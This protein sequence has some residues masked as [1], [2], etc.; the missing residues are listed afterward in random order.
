MELEKG[1]QR[2]VVDIAEWEPSSDDFSQAMAF[3]PHHEY[4]SIT[5]FV[6]LEDRK[7]A[8]VSR[9]LQYALVHQVLGITFD[10]IVIRRTPEGK[11]FLVGENVKL[12]F[13]NFNFNA[14]HHGDYV[15]IAS[16]PICLVG[17][18]IVSHSIPVN[19]TADKFIQSFSSYF[20]SLEWYCI[21]NAGSSD[22]MLKT[23]YRYWSLKESF[24][25]AM[26]SGVGYKLDEVE[27][28][29]KSWDDI[30]VKVAG[31]KLKDWKFWLLELGQNHSVSIARGHP[32]TAITSYKRTLKQTEFDDKEYDLG[33]H[34]PNASFTFLTV[35]DLI[36]LCS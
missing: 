35:K 22:E 33:L 5:R 24:V 20:S 1:V 26:G 7:R 8:L 11:P 23:F 34:L 25:K 16:E 10:D 28:H 30:F 6:K 29:H 32:R 27:F 21:L 12:G 18:D 9:L 31:R 2:W 15:A 4:A 3:L 13:P 19:E 17:V 14:S 36:Q